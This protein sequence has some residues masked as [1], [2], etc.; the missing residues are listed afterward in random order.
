[1]SFY[2]WTL[3]LETKNRRVARI[4]GAYEIRKAAGEL[5]MI[6]TTKKIEGRMAEFRRVA[7]ELAAFHKANPAPT[8]A[9]QV[10][11]SRMQGRMD[12]ILSITQKYLSEH[13]AIRESL[14][15]AHDYAEAEIA[16]LEEEFA[17]AWAGRRVPE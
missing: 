8:P 17:I 16:Q 12:G 6:D 11:S 7:S 5:R 10:K 3:A 4:A 1:M 9:Q 14:D 2:E 15:K 13:N